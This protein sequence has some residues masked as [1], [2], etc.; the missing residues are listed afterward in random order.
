MLL[1]VSPNAIQQLHLYAHVRGR[2]IR[3]NWLSPLNIGSSVGG[4]QSGCPTIASQWPDDRRMR[5]GLNACLGAMRITLRHWRIVRPRGFVV[6]GR[7]SE[8]LLSKMEQWH[9]PILWWYIDYAIFPVMS[10]ITCISKWER[11]GLYSRVNCTPHGT[12][13]ICM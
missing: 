5:N 9:R 12:I 11:V 6:K 8:T 4:D 3:I 2:T 1:A 10:T 7:S 13:H